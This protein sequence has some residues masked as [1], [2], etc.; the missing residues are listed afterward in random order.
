[1]NESALLTLKN[2]SFY[3]G[4]I[5]AV[6]DFSLS[7]KN[8]S[9]TTLLGPSG[10]G[11]TTLL[12]MISG[13]LEPCTG[14]IF[15]DGINQKNI[16]TEER[17]VGMVFQDYALFP[18]LSIQD[19][20]L[21]GLKIKAKKE[22]RNEKKSLQSEFN[23]AQIHKVARILGIA[24]LL[25]R[26]PHELSGGQQQR[27]ALG[28]ALVLEPRLLLMDEPLSS[29]DSRLR[30]SLR[31]EL[32]EI[33]S[34]LGITTVY[35][36]HDQEEAL[37]MSDTIAVINHG[38]LVQVGSPRSVYFTPA[39]DFVAGAVGR[40]NFFYLEGK[41]IAVRPEWFS[42]F[43]QGE[44]TQKPVVSG[45]LISTSFLGQATR[46]KIRLD[47][48]SGNVISADLLTQENEIPT[49]EKISLKIERF[50]EL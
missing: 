32:K 21:Y 17:K 20:L 26:F 38:R 19:N 28:R 12:R 49:G 4:K 16:P 24:D 11:K 6:S 48:G 8:G 47:D 9:F 15:I 2:V 5:A 41:R 46:Y 33:Q 29:L 42:K 35:V 18:H 44:I 14:S 30:T 40:A 23:F 37:S 27:V 13:F 36:T 3:F 50:I 10:C 43:V 45:I 31:E 25:E 22:R 1:M 39:N 34:R 7:V